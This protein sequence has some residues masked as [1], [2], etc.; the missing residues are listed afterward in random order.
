MFVT[1]GPDFLLFQKY[2]VICKWYLI[3]V[4]I[5]ANVMFDV[6]ILYI[7]ILYEKIKAARASHQLACNT[8]KET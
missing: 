3:K 8:G 7:I 1:L 5:V 2:Y 4:I 6:Q